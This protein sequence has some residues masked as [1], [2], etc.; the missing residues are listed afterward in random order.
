MMGLIKPS[1]GQVIINE[2]DIYEN[3]SDPKENL[4]DER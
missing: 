2:Q 1:N 4:L 3:N